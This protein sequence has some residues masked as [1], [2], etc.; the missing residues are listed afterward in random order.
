MGTLI[1][2]RLPKI[3]LGLVLAL[4]STFYADLR[5]PYGLNSR[6]LY[7]A[8]WGVTNARSKSAEAEY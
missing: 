2:G 3:G 4:S 8:L 6:D 5:T 1:E 7:W